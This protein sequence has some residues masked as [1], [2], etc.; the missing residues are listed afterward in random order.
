MYRY[1]VRAGMLGM[2]MACMAVA[3]RAQQT[4][5]LIEASKPN[6]G[7][8]FHDGREFPGAKGSLTLEA[9]GSPSR[10]PALALQGD[11]SGG[12][13]YVSMSRSVDP[14]HP[15]MISFNLLYPGAASLSMRLE[16]AN[17]TTHQLVIELDPR[18]TWQ[19]VQ[20][21]VEA[22]FK[23]MGTP[24][25][26]RGV[27]KYEKWGGSKGNF[28]P[29]LKA[30]TVI[31]GRNHLPEGSVSGTL[32]VAD[33]EI[34]GTLPEDAAAAKGDTVQQ[35]IR[36]DDLLRFGFNDWKFYK[37]HNGTKGGAEAVK[38]QPEA[39]QHALKFHADFSVEGTYAG[40]TKSLGTL[41]IDAVEAIHVRMMSPNMRM[42]AVQIHDAS[43]QTHQRKWISIEGDGQWRDVTIRP[44]AIV[45]VEKWGGANDGKLHQPVK[46][47]TILINPDSKNDVLAPELWLTDIRAVP[48]LATPSHQS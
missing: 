16:D 9:E 13:N 48:P 31:M 8:G 26:V 7:W 22:F 25:A 36:L 15:R 32:R 41:Q 18:D 47:L 39:G 3:A 29:P 28:T 42:Y 35:A 19:R 27:R 45:G 34:S 43:G 10:G 33:M 6:G 12:G 44:D 5:P 21:P 23:N 24:N 2:I 46:A 14:V 17:G 20:F 37:S 11:F 30:L 38:D 40:I 4:I 1:I